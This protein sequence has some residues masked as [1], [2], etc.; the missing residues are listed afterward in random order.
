MSLMFLMI[1][2]SL[3]RA[4]GQPLS[5]DELNEAERYEG[6]VSLRALR[7]AGWRLEPSPEGQRVRSVQVLTLPVFLKERGFGLLTALNAL[8]ATTSHAQILRESRLKAGEAFSHANALETER[9]LRATRLFSS[10]LVFAARSAQGGGAAGEGVD[11]IIITRDLWSLR[12]ESAFEY[13]GGVLSALQLNLT[14]RNLRG[15]RQSLS[16]LTHLT[17]FTLSTSL[18]I[19]DQRFGPDLSAALIAGIIWGRHSGARE[20]T[21]VSAQI[22]RPLYNLDQRWSLSAGVDYLNRLYRLTRGAQQV[23]DSPPTTSLPNEAPRPVE[24]DLK[25]YAA[26]LSLTRQWSGATQRSVTL[27]L[28]VSD[29]TRALPRGLTDAARARWR[30]EYLPPD[31]QQ[32]GPSVSA[33][34]SQRR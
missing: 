23:L 16:A 31:L 33:A 15:E 3:T 8:H 14:E 17:P 32:V 27:S 22:G 28:E 29:A 10:A 34:L 25:S 6:D 19:A 18:S 24:W 30:R 11:V 1:L 13:A 12:L 9:N 26:A 2:M 7:D 20:G 4:E 21:L 5:R